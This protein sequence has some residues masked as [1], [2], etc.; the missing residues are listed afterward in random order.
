VNLTPKAKFLNPLTILLESSLFLL[1][2][3]LDQS[4]KLKSSKY[5]HSYLQQYEGQILIA[6]Y[7]SQ[8]IPD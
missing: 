1:F 8:P 5:F 4:D 2:I 3:R 6:T 7:P